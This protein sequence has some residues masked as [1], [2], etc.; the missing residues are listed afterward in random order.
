MILGIS[1]PVA[2]ADSFTP[3]FTCSYPTAGP[4]CEASTP[5]PTTVDFPGPSSFPFDVRV[6]DAGN[7]LLALYA[8][9]AGIGPLDQPND[10]YQYLL[11]ATNGI[12]AFSDFTQTGNDLFANNACRSFVCGTVAFVGAA[13]PE[14]S[15]LLLL[16]AGLAVLFGLRRKGLSLV[17]GFGSPT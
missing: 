6:F 5:V 3:A 8:L 9:G 15:S 12:A 14:P 2:R 1:V 7:N 10:V 16:A 13:V 17:A 11:D 4:T